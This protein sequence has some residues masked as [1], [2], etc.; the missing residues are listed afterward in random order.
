M[1][2]ALTLFA[3]DGDSKLVLYTDA[4]IKRSESDDQVLAF[5]DFW[6]RIRRG[7]KPML[8]FDS[9]FTS[10]AKLSELKSNSNQGAGSMSKTG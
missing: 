10:Y 6:K 2:G 3:Q 8:V 9:K 4:D 5:L 7:V 1:K